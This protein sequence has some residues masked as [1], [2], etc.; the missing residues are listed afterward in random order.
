MKSDII[1]TVVSVSVVEGERVLIV[2]EGKPATFQKW[3]FP[4][5]RLEP[6]EAIIQAAIAHYTSM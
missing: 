3:N 4:G 5:G 6:G 1:L 2:Q